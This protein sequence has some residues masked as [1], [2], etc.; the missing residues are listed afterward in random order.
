MLP[1]GP[2]LSLRRK[3]GRKGLRI[4]L[5]CSNG[6]TVMSHFADDRVGLLPVLACESM[7][8]P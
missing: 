3:A 6:L 2:G 8:G 7:D 5:R 1:A 4:V